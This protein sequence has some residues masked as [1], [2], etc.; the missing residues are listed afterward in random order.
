MDLIQFQKKL[1]NCRICKNVIGPPLVWGDKKAK[2]VQ[3][4]QAPSQTAI[5]KQKVWSDAAGRRLKYEWYQ[6]SDKV[7]Y[8]PKNFYITALG[9][10]FPGKDKKGG[11]K[12]PPKICADKWLHK[13]ISYL[14]P[15]LF[16]VIG[17]MAATYL[18]P[19]K[20]YKELI[21]NDQKLNE[22]RCFVLPHPS[23]ANIK[24]FKDN[25]EF[26]KRR[27]SKIRQTIHQI[28]NSG[29]SRSV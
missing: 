23:P 22:I 15:K 24:W 11:D 28:L 18:F 8:N 9:H 4:S 6:V 10:C 12:K 27:L 13:E 20:E 29:L 1:K 16:I 7:F 19:G 14:K 25:P 26:G 21:F 3:I 5:K 2:I 17:K